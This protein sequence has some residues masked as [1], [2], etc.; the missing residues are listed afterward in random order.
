MNLSTTS[1]L[2]ALGFGCWALSANVLA[3]QGPPR[4][5]PSP[6]VHADRT[7][8]FRLRAPAASEVELSG[9]FLRGN[10]PME[11]ND[12]GM[13]IANVGPVEPN[14]Y[15]YNFVVDGVSVADPQ[16]QDL[17]PNEGFKASLVDVPGAEPAIH[18]VREVPH[19]QVIYCYYESEKFGKARPLLVYTPPGYAEASAPFPVFYLVSGTT[20]TEETWFRAG[21]FN[22][23]LDNLIADGKAQPMVVVLPYGNMRMGAPR[24]N[25]PEVADM[26]NAFADELVGSIMP[27]VEANFR[28][29]NDR[30]KRAIAGFSRGGGQSLF[31]G[32]SHLDKFGS[33]GSFSAYLT[34]EV[35]EKHFG[36]LAADPNATNEQIDLLWLGVGKQDFLYE[37]AVAFDK[38]LAAKKI[39]HESLITDG[40]HTWMNARHY[41]TETLQKLFVEPAASGAPG[42][43][44]IEDGG[45]GPYAAI[46]TEHS[47]LPGMTIFRPKDVTK[48]GGESKLPVLLWGNGACAN[49]PEE[50]KNFLN[51]LAS[52]GY[53]IL[54]IG[55]LDQL[56]QRGPAARERTNAKQ[57]TEALDW[58]EAEVQRSGSEYSGRVD[59]TKVA[60]MGMSCGG[61]QAIAISGD[62]R[63]DTTVVCNS[64]V[65]PEPSPMAAMPSLTK[66]DLKK[67][68][69][70]FIYIMGGPSDIA[71]NNA[72]D[73]FAR[74]DHVPIVM[75][76]HDVG[77]GGTYR[78]PHGGEF[79]RVALAWLDW[80]LNGDEEA[81]KQ[82]LEE[83]QGLRHDPKWTIDLKNL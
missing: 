50:H 60:A 40:G 31:T 56:E 54:A 49:T 3:Q 42:V 72:M 5:A 24:P 48:F 67:Y 79:S 39:D 17:F 27:Y 81:A 74:V 63:I 15:P 19:G 53:L 59:A 23:I 35:F 26:Y 61:L 46:A 13:W 73:D 57:L 78:Q 66:E 7:V 65:L 18:A 6:E 55:P 33:I 80:Q 29:A 25:S 77:H 70:P 58:I 20:D 22:F 9:Q 36:A 62:P 10:Q 38:F 71:Y 47:G 76:N 45:A 41:L 14:L 30:R 21:R 4:P 83:G 82:F 52:H 12:D 64:G 69:A 11:K 32:F 43:V 75:A 68:H 34:P 8:T 28:V 2:F 16:N 37:Q 1:R 51:E 44:T